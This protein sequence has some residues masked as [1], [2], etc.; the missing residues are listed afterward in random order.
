MIDPLGSGTT[1]RKVQFMSLGR[2]KQCLINAHTKTF[3]LDLDI[4]R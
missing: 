4:S 2:Y 1:L 3:N